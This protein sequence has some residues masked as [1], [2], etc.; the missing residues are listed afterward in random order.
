MKTPI[1]VLGLLLLLTSP[2][3]SA[4][5]NPTDPLAENLFPPEFVMQHQFDIGL[6]DDQRSALTATARQAF[7]SG[8]LAPRSWSTVRPFRLTTRSKSRTSPVASNT[9]DQP[10]RPVCWSHQLGRPTTR[11]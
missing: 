11:T 5:T 3:L 8:T 4:E 7:A 10:T 2:A 1:C 9:S 6:T